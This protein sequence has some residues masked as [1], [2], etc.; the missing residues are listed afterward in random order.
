MSSASTTRTRQTSTM[1]RLTVLYLTSLG[2]VAVLLVLFGGLAALVFQPLQSDY[3]N[4]SRLMGDEEIDALIVG[5]DVIQLP[6]VAVA[7]ADTIYVPQLKQVLA[8]WTNARAALNDPKGPNLQPLASVRTH[9]EALASLYRIATSTAT[10][11]VDEYDSSFFAP[12]DLDATVSAIAS[13]TQAFVIDM[14]PLVNETNRAAGDL[15]GLVRTLELAMAGTALLGLGATGF[16]IFR[17]AVRR[18]GASIVELEHA[19]AQ[20]RELA[21]LKDQFIVDANHELRTPIMAIYNNL[22]L[23]SMFEQR[24]RDDP[25]MRKDLIRQALNSGD[26]L[27]RLLNNVLDVSAL[28]AQAPRVDPRRVDLAPHVRFVLETFDPRDI[29]EAELAPGVFRARAVTVDVPDDLA[30]WADDGRLRQ[31]LIN[32]ISNALKYS[33]AGTPISI[34]ATPWSDESKR[35]HQGLEDA[36]QFVRVSVRDLGLGVPPRLMPQL[37]QRFVRLPRDIAGSARGNGVGLY[38]CRVLVEAMGGRIWVESTGVPGEGSTFSFILP[39]ASED[40]LVASAPL[41]RA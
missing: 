31:V 18:V 21:A 23:L 33:D 36:H 32:L 25:A 2:I 12:A 27:L 35:V 6:N 26:G 30:A 9:Y 17:P 41:A 37:F 5:Q 8:D 10:H 3:T 28:D 40:S 22:E 13:T 14:D 39:I 1:R 11:L 7:T 29:G 38:L 20:Q 4:A 34:S 19:E 24:G 16:F 15:F